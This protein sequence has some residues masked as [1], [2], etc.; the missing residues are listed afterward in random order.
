MVDDNTLE[1]VSP[2]E[3]SHG[4]RGSAHIKVLSNGKILK[5]K[6][7]Q[8]SADSRTI[9]WSDDIEIFVNKKIC[10]NKFRTREQIADQLLTTQD[11]SNLLGVS[12]QQV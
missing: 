10:G 9:I 2:V 5:D 3:D 7:E 6:K 4:K 1:F 12:K 11:V 8:F